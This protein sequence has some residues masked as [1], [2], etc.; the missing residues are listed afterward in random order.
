MKSNQIR[1]A[2]DGPSAGQEEGP[3]DGT[4]VHRKSDSYL[5][6]RVTLTLNPRRVS[7]GTLQASESSAF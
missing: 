1:G 2:L 3:K 7:M 6:I 4:P 5:L